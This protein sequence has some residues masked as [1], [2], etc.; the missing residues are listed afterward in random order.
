VQLILTD[1]G[2]ADAAQAQV[3]GA[4][5]NLDSAVLVAP[6]HGVVQQVNVATGQQVTGTTLPAAAAAVAQPATAVAA[7]FTHAIVLETPDAF[8]LSSAVRETDIVKVRVGDRVSVVVTAA[9]AT[10]LEG[11]V[12]QIAPAGTIRGNL[13]TFGLTVTF[14]APADAGLRTGMTA[15]MRIN[16]GHA[17]GDQTGPLTTP[18]VSPT[19]SPLASPSTTTTS[20]TSG[21]TSSTT[22][23]SE[24]A[25][26]TP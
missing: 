22:T 9:P 25:I 6:V 13:V 3:A 20:T 24:T 23:G 10:P 17:P 4:Q 11:T 7:P 14:E 16:V 18:G 19:R 2:Q 8:T 21:A 1:Q 26:P 5:H 12:T 15:R